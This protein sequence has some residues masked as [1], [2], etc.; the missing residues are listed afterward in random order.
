MR[1]AIA[2]IVVGLLSV[3][4]GWNSDYERVP[5]QDGDAVLTTKTMSVPER[6]EKFTLAAHIAVMKGRS[7]AFSF[8]SRGCD[9]HTYLSVLAKEFD[10]TYAINGGFF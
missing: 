2:I 9:N 8:V 7:T 6:G 3:C 10:C 5:S 1:V 4:L